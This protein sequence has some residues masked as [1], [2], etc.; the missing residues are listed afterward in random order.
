MAK[1]PSKVRKS[2]PKGS[3]KAQKP[4]PKGHF[5]VNTVAKTHG[6][7][8]DELRVTESGC[9]V[10]FV[11]TDPNPVLVVSPGAY[12]YVLGGAVDNTGTEAPENIFR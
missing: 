5:T 3:G 7:H 12:A 10:F 8:A 9:L 11:K 4:K 2:K 1:D 6:V